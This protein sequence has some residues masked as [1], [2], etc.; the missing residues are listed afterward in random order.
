[1]KSDTLPAIAS[2]LLNSVFIVIAVVLIYSIGTVCISWV[3]KRIY[4]QKFNHADPSLGY[5]KRMNTIRGLAVNAWR[6]III[7]VGIIAVLLQFVDASVLTPLFAGA[8][9]L[10]VAV[11]FGSQALV[12]DFITGLFII[13]E[14]QYRVGDVVDISGSTG[15]VEQIGAR[16]TVIRDANGDVHFFPNGTISHVINKTM[17]YSN[18]HMIVSVPASANLEKTIRRLNSI[19]EELANDP[20]WKE[21]IIDPLHFT[22]VGDIA[23]DKVQLAVSGQV[24]P[25]DQWSVSAEYRKRAL[26]DFSKAAITIEVDTKNGTGL[27][28]NPGKQKRIKQKPGILQE[29]SSKP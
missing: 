29:I 27:G 12:K 20:E 6:I 4:T 13:S 5:K 22:M 21:R 14:N 18:A 2:S 17:S 23:D 3:I 25:A 26:V 24:M 10:S 19:G 8:G 15:T 7:S 9:I 11:G 1:M 28:P 16:S